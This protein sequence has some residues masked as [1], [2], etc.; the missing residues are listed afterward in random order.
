LLSLNACYVGRSRNVP[1]R[2]YQIAPC[3]IFSMSKALGHPAHNAV[4]FELIVLPIDSPARTALGVVPIF[5]SDQERKIYSWIAARI[6][7]MA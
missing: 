4:W 1:A 5:T 3:W 7:H 6:H 2:K